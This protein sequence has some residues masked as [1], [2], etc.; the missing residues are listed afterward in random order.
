[1]NEEY[2]SITEFAKRAGVSRPTIYSRLGK[3]LSNFCK[4]VKGRKVINTAALSLF[5]VKDF[6]ESVKED[7]KSVKDFTESVK[8]S[9]KSVKFFTESVK[10]DGKSVKDFTESVKESVKDFTTIE[11]LKSVIEVLEKELEIKNEQIRSR[12][13]QIEDL[14]ERMKEYSERLSESHMLIGRQQSLHAADLL[15]EKTTAA[16]A[17][18]EP[19]PEPVQ[20]VEKKRGFFS[21]WRKN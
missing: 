9:V 18:D 11:A 6:T 14:S 10:E 12:D 4:T 21:F 19:D 3:E 13:K 7:G 8:E 20:R 16:P 17:A 2:I 1:M 5:G 15:E